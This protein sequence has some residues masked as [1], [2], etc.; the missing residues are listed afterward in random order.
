MRGLA[1]LSLFWIAVGSVPLA[2]ERDD[3]DVLLDRLG[4][5]LVAYEPRLSTIVADEMYDQT[6]V[7]ITRRRSV[8]AAPGPASTTLRDVESMRKRRMQSDVAFL[9]LPGGSIWFGVRDVRTVDRKAVASATPRLTELLSRLNPAG[10]KEATTIVAQS[11]QHNLGTVRTINMPTVP[12]ELL[13]P[14]H[15][16]QFMFKVRGT[17]KIAGVRTRRLDF[18]EFDEPTLISAV[19][20]QPLFVRGTAWIEPESG[21]VWRV[22]FMVRAKAQADPG[23]AYGTLRVD[24]M[25]HRELGMMVP[26]EMR[27]TFWIPGGR[28][29]G[30]ARY[31]N[32]RQFTTSARIVP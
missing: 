10:L 27:E 28:G 23:Q 7:K 13:H 31:S 24:Y 19:E 14:D 15:H 25:P 32:F 5:Y 1:A 6:E 12:L 29:D 16:V 17:E 20:G 8:T 30:H 22:Q 26:K 21:T 11:A 3:L 9:R 4:R 18:E 2:Q